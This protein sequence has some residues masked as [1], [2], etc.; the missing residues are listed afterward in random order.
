M[1]TVACV[2]PAFDAAST[3]ESVALGLRAA[4]P[5]AMLIVVDDGSSDHTYDVAQGSC[6]R[7]VRLD[8]NHGKGAALR[9]GFVVA[10]DAQVQAIVTID[11]DGQ[12]DPARAPELVA[13]LTDADVV[14]GARERTRGTM[15][16]G[17]RVTNALASAA[18]GAIVGVDVPDAQSGYRAMRRDVLER[19]HA[20][21][22]RYEYETEFL[23]EAARAGYRIASVG[24]PTMYGAAS[25]FRTWDDSMLV[26]RAI[27]RHRAG[28]AS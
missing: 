27:W 14:I 12:H 2:I 18:V 11:A 5:N 1:T 8:S 23:I 4:L 3:I 15:P 26:V 28:R 16:L 24:V 17:R 9:A 25:H 10:L 20:T 22:D 21:G 7:V 19:V 6:D 13:A